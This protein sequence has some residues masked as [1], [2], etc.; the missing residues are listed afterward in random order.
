MFCK[1]CNEYHFGGSLCPSCGRKLGRSKIRF[2]HTG[3][4]VLYEQEQ[5]GVHG[6]GMAVREKKEKKHS[7]GFVA[8]LCYKFI[9]SVMAC[10][11]FS[12]TFRIVL[13]LVKLA[14]S[15]M[16]TGGEI[17]G[18]ISFYADIKQAINWFEIVVWLIIFILI[19]R[20]RYNPE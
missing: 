5:F 20:Y 15:L 8:R 10:V 16:E 11:L 13:F 14:D 12:V 17:R 19:F 6:G 2:S 3:E 7:G 4:P 1:Q 18:G 9:E